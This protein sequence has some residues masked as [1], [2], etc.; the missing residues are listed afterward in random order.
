MKKTLFLAIVFVL[1]FQTAA[2]AESKIGAFSVQAVLMNCDYGKALG[3]KLKAKFEPMQKELEREQ[4]AIQKLESDLKNQ[5][6][7]LKLDAKQDKQRE[8]RRRV[9][10]HQDSVVAFRQKF[11]VETQQG[12]QPVLERIIRVANEYGK[13]NGYTMIVEMQNVVLYLNDAAD[14][15]DEIVAELNKLKKAGK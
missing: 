11:Q 15:T 1:L 2:I 6:M 14:I 4:A 8:F 12:Q 3:A 10:D 7:A 13:A 5:D 9:R